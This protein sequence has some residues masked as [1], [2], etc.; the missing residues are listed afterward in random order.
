MGCEC[1]VFPCFYK[2]TACK[3]PSPKVRSRNGDSGGTQPQAA[4][5]GMG[6]GEDQGVAVGTP[7]IG[8]SGDGHQ[9]PRGDKGVKG[10]G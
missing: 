6:V 5:I 8:G 2:A 7:G 3:A 9:G 10:W 4:E 1:N